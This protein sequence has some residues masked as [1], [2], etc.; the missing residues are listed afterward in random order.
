MEV[1]VWKEETGVEYW[2]RGPVLIQSGVC[3]PFHVCGKSGNSWNVGLELC[4]VGG[5]D[6]PRILEDVGEINEHSFLW[7]KITLKQ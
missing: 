7:I 5:P 1:P 6:K 4:K 3:R 2:P